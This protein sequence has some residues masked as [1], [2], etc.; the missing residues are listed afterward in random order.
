MVNV[1]SG[2]QMGTAEVFEERVEKRTRIR[3]DM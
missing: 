2:K 3:V 1:I